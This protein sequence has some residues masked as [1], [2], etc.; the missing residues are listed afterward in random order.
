[1]REELILAHRPSSTVSAFC[2]FLPTHTVFLYITCVILAFAHVPSAI[3]GFIC[4]PSLASVSTSFHWQNSLLGILS[5]KTPRPG[6]VRNWT[7]GKWL[8]QQEKGDTPRRPDLTLKM[9]GKE[10]DSWRPMS[11]PYKSNTAAAKSLRSCLTL[12]DLIDGSPPGSSVHR[13]LKGKNTGVGCCFLL[14]SKGLT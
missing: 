7:S 2:N 4:L 3:P 12:C 11:V 6:T 8:E 1:M 9:R 5:T 14:Q 10:K 13:I